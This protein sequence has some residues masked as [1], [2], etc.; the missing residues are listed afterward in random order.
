MRIIQKNCPNCNGL[1]KFDEERNTAVCPYCDSTFVCDLQTNESTQGKPKQTASQLVEQARVA[2]DGRRY[3]DSLN[4][5]KKALELD[6]NNAEAK[7][8]V[9]MLSGEPRVDNI[10]IFRENYFLASLRSFYIF[11]D[12]KEIGTVKNGGEMK[13][14]IPVGKHTFYIRCCGGI[15]QIVTFEIPTSFNKAIVKTQLGPSNFNGP[16][17]IIDITIV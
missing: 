17:Y 16:T 12:G 15:S 6:P 1:L 10:E 8:N 5:L 11:V 3:E 7:E 9:L 13:A 14:M 4:Y 2:F